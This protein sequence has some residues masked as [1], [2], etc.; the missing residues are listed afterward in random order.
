MQVKKV[1]KLEQIMTLSLSLPEVEIVQSFLCHF[2][3][4]WKRL[5]NKLT[6]VQKCTLPFQYISTTKGHEKVYR[7]KLLQVSEKVRNQWEG[8]GKI[9]PTDL[10]IELMETLNN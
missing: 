9:R 4:T 3:V 8:L 10:I 5:Q 1:G 7:Q 6:E 2:H